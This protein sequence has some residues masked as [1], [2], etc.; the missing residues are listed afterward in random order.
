MAEARQG[1]PEFQTRSRSAPSGRNSITRVKS[2]SSGVHSRPARPEAAAPTLGIMKRRDLLLTGS[3]AAAALLTARRASAKT[4]SQLAATSDWES[5]RATYGLAPDITYLNHASIGT[6]PRPLADARARYLEL[7]ETNPWLYM[8]GG[9]WEEGRETTRRRS[10]ALLGC[11]GED[12]AITHNTTEGFNLLAQGLPLAAGDEVLFSSLNHSGASVCW[13]H[14]ARRRGYEVRRFDFPVRDAADLR[15]E[16][17]VAL[18]S[19]QITGRT[20]VLV[21][22]HVDNIVGLRY[23]LSAMA[24]MAHDA[25]VQYVA[26]D[27]AQTAGMLPL[28]LAASGVDFYSTS[29][30]KWIQAPKGTGL[31]YVRRAMREDVAPMWMTWGQARWEGTVRVMEDYGTRNLAEVLVLGDA[32]ALQLD[33]GGERVDSRLR[34]L[35][36]YAQAAVEASSRLR[37]RSPRAWKDGAALFAVEATG[38][39]AGEASRRLLQ[40]HGIV[41]RPFGGDLNTMRL[42]PNVTTRESEID[43]FI[44]AVENL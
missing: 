19:A 7:C 6:M 21:F 38:V 29:G 33:L 32:I 18:Y 34:E 4:L 9:A 39:Q 41:L 31:L 22:P 1:Y 10:G 5:L 42:S 24:A 36:A 37:W 14:Q 11:D 17:V 3:S 12:V 25:G 26:V 44:R 13:E 30:H 43:T 20:R 28:D 40:D 23:P 8:W 16:D 15:A 35:R 2:R 27:G